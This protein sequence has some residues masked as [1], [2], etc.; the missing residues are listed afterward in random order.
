MCA[1]GAAEYTYSGLWGA[2]VL[3]VDRTPPT[4][5]MI[6]IYRMHPAHDHTTTAMECVFS[7]Q[8]YECMTYLSLNHLFHTFEIDGGLIG[9]S[10]GDANESH[11]FL[12]KV[13]AH[14]PPHG[15]VMVRPQKKPGLLARIF[16]RS[17]SVT[18][19]HHQQ[20]QS[21]HTSSMSISTPTH[22][23]KH[24][25]PEEWSTLFKNAATHI[26]NQQNKNG[27]RT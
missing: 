21:P 16:R 23:V 18:P 10:F 25:L 5:K 14:I 11:Q 3:I 20:Q 12:V 24:E 8:I 27:N 4:C 22:V 17:G 9:L 15:T 2:L 13:R 26:A 1:R 19:P 7:F 6:R